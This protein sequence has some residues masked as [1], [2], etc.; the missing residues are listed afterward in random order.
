MNGFIEDFFP[1]F[2]YARDDSGKSSFWLSRQ[3][4]V[5]RKFK[6]EENNVETEMH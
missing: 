1:N 5:L 6:I 2:K 4:V 3:A